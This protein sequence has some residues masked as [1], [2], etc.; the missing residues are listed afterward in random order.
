VAVGTSLAA[1]VVDRLSDVHAVVLI[2]LFATAAFAGWSDPGVLRWSGVMLVVVLS[3]LV[4]RLV[5]GSRWGPRLIAFLARHRR[6]KRLADWLLRA[7]GDFPRLWRPAVA[8]PSIALSLLAYGL[9]AAIFAGMVAK[10]APGFSPWLSA[11][12]FASATL[13]GAASFIPGGIG[14]ME[15]ALVVMLA[16]HGV[17]SA[18]GLA[19][20]L[21]LR[22]VTFWLGLLLGAAGLLVAGR[23]RH[24]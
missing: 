20:A 1:F 16:G 19:A 14:A 12:I 24:G 18:S 7:S 23:A 17:D 22:A 6:L 21:C 11:A 5:A 15:L 9:Q 2:A 3:G 4:F 8:L 13:L 10:V